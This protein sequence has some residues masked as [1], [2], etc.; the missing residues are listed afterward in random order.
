MN[1]YGASPLLVSSAAAD[2]VVFQQL[3]DMISNSNAKLSQARKTVA[4][5]QHIIQALQKALGS[6]TKGIYDT[7]FQSSTFCYKLVEN[8]VL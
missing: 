2:N 3:T 4:K 6:S 1:I 7:S 8:S 5:Q